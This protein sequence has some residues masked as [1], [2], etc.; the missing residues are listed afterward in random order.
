M[1]KCKDCKYAMT[2]ASQRQQF[3]RLV[4]RGFSVDDTK[5]LMPRCQKCLTKLVWNMF[6]PVPKC[7]LE[8]P[9]TRVPPSN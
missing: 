7:D 2:W 4:K 1:N 6:Q 5:Q 9:G 3:G 8:H